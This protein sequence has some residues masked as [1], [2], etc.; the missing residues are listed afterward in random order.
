MKYT[1][2][3]ALSLLAALALCICCF[4]AAALADGEA[5]VTFYMNDGTG[6][7]YLTTTYPDGGRVTQPDDPAPNPAAG[8][9]SDEASAE[10]AAA[11]VTVNSNAQTSIM[12]FFVIIRYFIIIPL[13]DLF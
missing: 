1:W 3:K 8:S 5:T 6:D 9:A 4:G 13:F 11:T 2:K 7:I 12:C 10:P